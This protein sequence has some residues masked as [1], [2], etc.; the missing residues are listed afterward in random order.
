MTR[1]VARIEVIN[2]RNDLLSLDFDSYNEARIEYV[3]YGMLPWIVKVTL[4]DL[5]Q[6]PPVELRS[7]GK[8]AIRPGLG[9]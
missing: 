2:S 5:T 4:W 6:D 3:A 8:A 9:A 1:K 7:S